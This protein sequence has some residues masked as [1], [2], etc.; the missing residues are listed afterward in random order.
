[1]RK[2]WI[3]GIAL[4]AL[5]G[6][7]S[8]YATDYYVKNDGDDTKAGTSDALAWK[9]IAKVNGESFSGDD[10]IYFKRGDTWR[11]QLTVPDSGTSGHQITFGAYG[12]GADPIINANDLVTTWTTATH[13][14]EIAPDNTCT[15]LETEANA[16]TG[17]TDATG[18]DTFESSD[19]D[20]NH[21]TYSLHLVADSASERAYG[22]FTTVSGETYDLSFYVKC[23]NEDGDTWV[24]YRV[25]KSLPNGQ[26][27]QAW[28]N[29]TTSGNWTEV[30]KQFAATGT[31]MYLLLYEG[32]VGDDAEFYVD[33][34][35]LKE[36]APANVWE[37]TCTTEPKQVFFDGTRG[38]IQAA[39]EDVDSANDWYWAGN[40]LYVY[41]TEDPD[42]AV[43]IEAGVRGQSILIDTKDYITIDGLTTSGGAWFGIAIKTADN[44]IVQN[45]LNTKA[46]VDGVAA[47]TGS[48]N[49]TMDSNTANWNGACGLKAT[50]STGITITNN[51]VHN[52]CQL[53]IEAQQEYTAGIKVYGSI[54]FSVQA[55][56]TVANNTIYYEG[57]DS[58]GEDVVTGY[59]GGGVHFD[60]GGTS[61]VA[62]IVRYNKIYDCR[63][64][65]IHIE[66][67]TY[68]AQV[69][70]N[71]VYSNDGRGIQIYNKIKNTKVYNNV[72][73]DNGADGIFVGGD[74]TASSMENNLINNNI[75]LGNDDQ[76]LSCAYGG[77]NDGT[78]GSGNVY[79][80]NCFGDEILIS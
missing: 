62:R 76:Q 72:C 35:S 17:W 78:N 3:L 55:N 66:L 51:T 49:I 47:Y 10:I 65:G 74:G 26:E 79:T 42:G 48:S 28:T 16:T 12:A 30:T 24:S 77:E 25:G 43:V 37:A 9:T 44:I 22:T 6:A 71:L 8:L 46:Y 41:Y 60:A 1:M 64:Y 73:Y 38:N 15:S 13:G 11:E 40:V 29:I 20:K 59:R 14:P 61:D 58:G 52:N 67:Q 27:Y 75:C 50:N 19:V 21:G 5:L 4:T 36:V 23:T 32:G 56:A 34:V 68:Y 18:W 2:H 7:G 70:Y 63:S 57:K 53:D 69:Y 31:T 39:I 45:C 33:S 54:D 80:H